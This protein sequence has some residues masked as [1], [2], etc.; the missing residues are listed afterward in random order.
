MKLNELKIEY[1]EHERHTG[2]LKFSNL[3]EPLNLFEE[4]LCE[5]R[6]YVRNNQPQTN[7]QSVIK[8]FRPQV[9]DATGATVSCK[10]VSAIVP[11][12]IKQLR[13]AA[14]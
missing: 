9:S 12:L 13:D 3:I 8:V 4:T 10:P 14:R 11:E 2:S 5:A 7:R 6:A 1:K